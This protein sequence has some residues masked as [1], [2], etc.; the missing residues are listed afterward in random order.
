MVTLWMVLIMWGGTP[1][2]SRTLSTLTSAVSHRRRHGTILTLKQGKPA[3]R[4]RSATRSLCI[5]IADIYLANN[6]VGG[7]S[8][9]T[10]VTAAY[11]L[12]PQGAS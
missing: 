10:C 4:S 7:A 8:I 11:S 6:I 1:P 2:S 12:E 9:G 5:C 3:A